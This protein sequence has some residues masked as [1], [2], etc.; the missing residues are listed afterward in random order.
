MI[1]MF[2]SISIHRTTAILVTRPEEGRLTLSWTGRSEQL[3]PGLGGPRISDLL[4]S[5]AKRVHGH[6]LNRNG[7]AG[8]A[9]K[10]T[11]LE[12]EIAGLRRLK[13]AALRAKYR[14]LFGEDSRSGHRQFL[15]RRVVWR[16]QALA[17][18]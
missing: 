8:A 15:F 17:P 5:F 3:R 2:R 11:S 14:E 10:A 6:V 1:R 9:R 16:L 12:A 4:Y 13:A 18:A 7:A